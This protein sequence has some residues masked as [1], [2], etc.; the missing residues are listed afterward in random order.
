MPAEDTKSYALYQ[1]IPNPFRGVTTIYFELP[2]DEE[3]KISLFDLSGKLIR[4]ARLSGVRGLNYYEVNMDA[5]QSG[6]IYYQ[7]ETT[8]FI[9]TRKMVVIK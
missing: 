2:K 9:A 4:S 1:N 8:D 5:D 7:L 6:I 3:V